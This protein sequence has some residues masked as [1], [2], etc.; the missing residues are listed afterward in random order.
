MKKSNE[1][2]SLGTK[3]IEALMEPIFS[4]VEKGFNLDANQDGN[5]TGIEV[6]QGAGAAIFPLIMNWGKYKVHAIAAKKEWEDLKA[7][8]ETYN[9]VQKLADKFKLPQ[10]L[11]A[12]EIKVENTIYL[13]A[14][15]YEYIDST[16]TGDIRR[17]IPNNTDNL[18]A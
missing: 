8:G 4:T 1:N 14:Q 2:L 3:N 16:W 5:I 13:A 15:V 17:I 18:A 12:V 10:K 9:V 7:G 11:E 6:A